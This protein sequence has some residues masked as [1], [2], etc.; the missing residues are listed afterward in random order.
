[1]TPLKTDFQPRI[2]KQKALGQYLLR[3]PSFA[4]R[5]AEAVPAAPLVVEIGSGDGSL[6]SA[7]LDAGHRVVGIELDPAMSAKLERRF[8][9]RRDFRLRPG[10]VL[11]VKWAEFASETPEIIIAGNLPY[12]LTSPILFD[13][14]EFVRGG[15][16]PRILQMVVMVQKE[17]GTRLAASPGGKAYNNLTLL[18]AYH[19]RIEYLFTVPADRFQPR[20]AVDGAVIRLILRTQNELPEINYEDFR[21]LVRGCF[22]QRRKMMRNALQVVNDLPEGW[23]ELNYDWTLRPEQFTF[24][25]FLRL[26]GDLNKLKPTLC[27]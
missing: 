21:R 14:F 25:D 1:M 13:V 24:E 27:L 7:L 9:H 17:V 18:A 3:D 8:I 16:L 23:E 4:R 11:S 22:A 19:S 12:H 26:A 15:G 2:D 20:P 10:N 5:I 6:T